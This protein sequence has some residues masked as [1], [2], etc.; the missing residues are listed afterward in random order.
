MMTEQ[1]QT[2]STNETESSDTTASETQEQGSS[3]ST[4]DQSQPDKVDLA[5]DKPAATTEEAKTPEQIA[6]EAAHAELFGAP[7][8]GEAYA[9]EGLPEGMEI[10]KDAL[11]AVTP[12]FRELGLSAKGASKVAQ[13]YAEKVLP[14]VMEQATKG[15]EAQVIATRASWEAD[16][17]AA[18]KANGAELKNKSGEVLSFDAKNIE[19][20]RSVAAKA[21][22]RLAPD[23][24]RE[25]LAET[26]LSVHPAMVAFAYQAGKL[27]AEDASLETTDT[28][29]KRS[30]PAPSKSG[31][32]HTDRFFNR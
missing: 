20:V 14:Q 15:I 12:T 1:E 30:G 10:D 4:T 11:E 32:M 17:V 6:A 2:T 7:A 23:G 18:V 31:G 3:T 8:E 25:F 28:G 29:T 5:D 19:A 21:L 13:V 16:A 27:I 22:D 24:F 26:G 9:I